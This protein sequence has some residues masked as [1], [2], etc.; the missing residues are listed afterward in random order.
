[1]YWLL[2]RVPCAAG[3]CTALL[4][5]S[6]GGKSFVKFPAPPLPDNGS[7]PMLRFADRRDGFAFVPQ[8]GGALYVTH[9]GGAHWRRRAFGTVLQFT[10]AGGYAYAV[11]ARC[12]TERCTRYR[13]RRG[14]VTTNRWTAAALPF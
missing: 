12:S 3:R 4:R 5:T 9:D 11:T 1:D 10:T 14:A 7:V 8:V 13:F 6:D 2:G